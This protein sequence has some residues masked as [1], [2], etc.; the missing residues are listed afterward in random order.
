M[1]TCK[2]CSLPMVLIEDGQ[3]THPSCDPPS[4]T[5]GQPPTPFEHRGLTRRSPA[6]GSRKM[7]CSPAPAS[8]KTA[9]IHSTDPV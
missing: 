8:A 3:T 5:S 4:E 7:N 6:N 2:T 9:A 1:T